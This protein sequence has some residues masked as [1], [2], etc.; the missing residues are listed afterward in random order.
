MAIKAK[1]RKRKP[2]KRRIKTG[3]G[4]IRTDK[5]WTV[6]GRLFHIDVDSK[7][8]EAIVK[9]YV[10]KTFNKADAQ[11]ILKTPSHYWSSNHIAAYCFWT[12]NY[13]DIEL[14][15]KPFGPYAGAEN[16]KD[17]YKQSVGWMTNRFNELIEKGK[18]IVNEIK[19][20]EKRTK[21]LYKPSIQDRM[22]EQ[23]SDIIGE[24]E[25]VCDNHII[26]RNTK[27]DPKFFD[28]L[29]SNSVAQ[30]HISKIKSFYV[31]IQAEFKELLNKD[32]HPDLKEG[33]D[34]LSKK[35]I[36]HTIKFFD[37]MFSDLD[38]YANLKKATRKIRTKKAPSKDK[39]VAKLKFKQSDSEYKI[40]S[41]NPLDILEATELWVFNTK[42]RK[43]GKYVADDHQILSVKGTTLV[44]FSERDS[45]QKTLRKPVEK[46]QE[47]NKAGK[48][49][50][51]KF[52]DDIKATETKL[53]GR[54]NEH[55]VLLKVSK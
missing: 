5:G 3:A 44:G 50:L 53:N 28:W 48:V 15:T 37:N 38:A 22:A 54:L 33:Y 8:S 13:S 29:K 4:A 21:N 26:L 7:D 27:E 17:A 43:L 35:E 52:M 11:A 42:N 16:D 31:P 18:G 6:F 25:V 23:L 10:R 40:A 47:F 49:A 36:N 9:S 55:T 1:T 2:T 30:A 34:H 24:F 39:L 45:V 41:V 19:K 51:R 46:L 32:C 14:P 12:E 20:E